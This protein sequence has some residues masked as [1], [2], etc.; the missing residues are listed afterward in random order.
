MN[1]RKL[2]AITREFNRYRYPEC[3]ARTIA[4]KNGVLIVEFS[5]TSTH[6]CCFDEHF[7]DYRILLGENV[8]IE[9]V[10]DKGDRFIVFY[11]EV[12]NGRSE[13]V[14]ERKRRIE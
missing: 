11:R 10:D 1:P 9:E 2:R 4:N 6:S 14:H 13:K 7:E 8:N 5:G 12:K 3:R